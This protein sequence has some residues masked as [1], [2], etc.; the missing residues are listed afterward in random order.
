MTYN[1]AIV[2]ITDALKFGI[3]PGLQKI[4]KVCNLLDDPQLKYPT[5]HITGTNGKTSTAWMI[6]RLLMKSGLKTGC[7]TSPHLHSYRERISINGQMISEDD[8]AK[9]LMA[10][11]PAL[12]KAKAE[13]GDLTEF[14]ILTAMAFHYFAERKVD[15]A[16]FEVGLGGRWDATSVIQPKVAV[17][18]G[19]AL[20]HTDRLGNTIEEIAWDKAHIIKQGCIA[21]V[22]NAKDGALE[23]IKDRCK[24]ERA[25][26]KLLGKD[27]SAYNVSIYKNKGSHFS[28]DGIFARYEDINLRALGKYQIGN[29]TMAVAALEAF[30]GAAVDVNLLRE[31]ASEIICPGRFELVARQPMVVLD[32]AHNPDGLK[33]LIEELPQFF[34]FSNLLVVLAISNDKD[35]KNMLRL[36]ENHASLIIFTKNQSPRSADISQLANVVSQTRNSYIIEPSLEKAINLAISMASMVDLIC[37]TGSLYTVADAREI[38]V[39]RNVSVMT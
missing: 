34:T 19:I 1:D 5:I 16:V 7:Y 15:V 11:K 31:A 33:A 29:F 3:N 25:H 39:G 10:I 24:S 36:L 2:Y 28:I 37:V 4:K 8:F 26:M 20:D 6:A 17:I 12:E 23:Q 9:S 13:H 18:T 27:F 32:G 21:V 38:L 22:G 30:N 35:I 14:E